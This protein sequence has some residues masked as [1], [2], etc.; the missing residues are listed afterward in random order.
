MIRPNVVVTAASRR[1]ALV[2]ALQGALARLTPHG[3]VVATDI[4]AFSPA[5]HIADAAEAVPRSDHPDYVTALLEVCD[6]HDAGILVPTIDDELETIAAAADRFAAAGVVVMGPG[7][8]TARVCRDKLRTAAHLQRHGIRVAATWSP[9]QVRDLELGPPL[10]IKPRCGRGSVGAFPIRTRD[11]L[12]FFLQYVADPVVQEYLEG[13]EFTI[14]L[15]CDMHGRPI[16]A[17][18]RERL[19]I[20]AGVT[21]RGRTVRSRDLMDL[22]VRC[23]AVLPFRGAVNVQ[24]RVVDGTPVIFEI[25]PRFSGGIQL[26]VAAGADFAEW[27]IRVARGES[28]RPHLGE[29]TDALRMSSYETSLFLTAAAAQ[30]LS[31]R[32]HAMTGEDR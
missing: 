1:V 6:A 2:R 23:A 11:Q 26:T 32:D 14:D 4:D 9:A 27:T 20:R 30:V 8:E 22:A 18:P 15:F 10:F 25:N 17:V 13:P 31:R 21:D 28:L 5:V 12:R 29:F 24:C 16:S 19:V 7:V 3:R